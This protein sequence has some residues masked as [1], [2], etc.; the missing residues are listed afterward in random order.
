MKMLAAEC[1]IRELGHILGA[2]SDTGVLLNRSKLHKH[3]WFIA[4]CHAGKSC[5]CSAQQCS[6]RSQGSYINLAWENKVERD[7]GHA[8]TCTY[9]CY[10]H[11]AT[12]VRKTEGILLGE[13]P[14]GYSGS[15]GH[16]EVMTKG[17]RMVVFA[18]QSDIP[19]LTS[20]CTSER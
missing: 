8:D 10:P 14:G 17:S 4:V 7:T 20:P 15:I 18:C 11:A 9:V 19:A 5:A 3:D 6:V 1:K 2:V 13:G 12:E 16:R